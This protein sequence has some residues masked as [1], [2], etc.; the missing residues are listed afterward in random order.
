VVYYDP[1]TDIEA[2]T[3]FLNDM[4]IKNLRRE[5]VWS[6]LKISRRV[7]ESQRPWKNSGMPREQWEE[8]VLMLPDGMVD[9]IYL[10]RDAEMLV[11]NIFGNNTDG[12]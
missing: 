4:S 11:N 1:A 2:N 7:Y 12:K 9:E 6:R 3:R 8:L 5:K 10:E